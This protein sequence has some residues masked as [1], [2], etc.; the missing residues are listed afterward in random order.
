MPIVGAG[1]VLVMEEEEPLRKMLSIM[2]ELL[3]Y[4]SELARDGDEAIEL[5]KQAMAS[6][7]PHNVVISDLTVN[8]GI[9]GEGTIKK[10]LQIDPDVKAVISSGYLYDAVLTDYKKYGFTA[11]LPKPCTKKALKN[12]LSKVEMGEKCSIHA[13]LKLEHITTF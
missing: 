12:V 9:G 8:T 3:G 11:A 7:Q 5:Y 1:K 13:V 10:L 4:E 6:G 2:L